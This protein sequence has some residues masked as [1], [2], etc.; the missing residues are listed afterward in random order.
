MA[1]NY[2]KIDLIGGIPCSSTFGMIISMIS[3]CSA[4]DFVLRK[5]A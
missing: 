2:Y 5:V 3:F 1:C 4:K